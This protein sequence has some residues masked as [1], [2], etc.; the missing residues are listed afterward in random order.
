M[1]NTPP[2]DRHAAMSDFGPEL[3]R[4]M[5]ARGV[6]VRE[7]AR[8]AHYNA[9]HISNLRNGKKRPSPE[10][11]DRLDR[12][13]QADGKL[14]SLGSAD[15]PR[16][17]PGRAMVEGPGASLPLAD[18]LA[19]AWMVGRLDQPVDRAT[20]RGLAATLADAPMMGLA[21]PTDRIAHALA[22]PAGG[23]ADSTVEHLE[24]VSL[25]LHWLE[26]VLPARQIIRPALTH[27]HEAISLLE[28]C[29]DDKQRRRLAVTAGETA[30]LGAWAAWD[31]GN[32]ARA[33]SLYRAA[34][35]AARE[36]N[37]PAI[38]A[39]A[40]IYRSLGAAGL[41][42]HAHAR[43][44][45][46]GARHL[47]GRQD[48]ATRAWL[49]A[50]EA[51]E[52]AALGD[53]S[54]QETIKVATDALASA[55]PRSER[56]WTRCLESSQWTHSRL[57][58]ATRIGD[59][60]GVYASVTDLLPYAG[61]PQQK[62]TGRLLATIGLALAAIGDT[63]EAVRFGWRSIE[64]VKISKATYALSRLSELGT[65]LAD[66]AAPGA[67]ELREAIGAT[68]QELAPPH[69]STSGSL[70]GPQ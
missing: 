52:A 31:L 35:L 1:R 9:G 62:K 4:L 3:Q 63:S 15:A 69:P 53:A 28:A 40:V 38:I 2:H 8:Q 26:F 46:A 33:A 32:A 51:E 67:R 18:L 22:H 20:V 60:A 19:V 64:A 34:E 42:A 65:V 27:L 30:L 29:A 48:P 13:L 11:A 54:A 5:Q 23:L 14:A 17:A 6:G 47:P 43:E 37:D 50:R 39:C 45:L 21:E 49:C 70:P 41:P 56:S 66:D 12:I 68:R 25:G 7:L 57:C 61:D 16:R 36:G 24:T 10:T 55:H 58:I 44:Q 59:R